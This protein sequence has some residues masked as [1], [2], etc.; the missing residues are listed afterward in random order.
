[1]AGLAPGR[2]VEAEAEYDL[3]EISDQEIQTYLDLDQKIRSRVKKR[4]E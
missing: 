1:M 4:P 2:E 3:S